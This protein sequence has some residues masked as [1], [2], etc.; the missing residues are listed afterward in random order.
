MI[1][2]VM[3]PRFGASKALRRQHISYRIQ[4]KAQTSVLGPYPFPCTHECQ[5]MVC[6]LFSGI[7]VPHALCSH[8]AQLLFYAVL[9]LKISG[10]M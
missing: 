4:P 9:T 8:G 6:N 3:A 1:F 10:D 2:M 7:A 5:R